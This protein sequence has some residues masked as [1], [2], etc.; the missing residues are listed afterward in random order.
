MIEEGF[1]EALY[2]ILGEGQGPEGHPLVDPH[3][4]ADRRRLAD[5]APVP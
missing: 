3:P 2:C 1:G 5:D 4:P